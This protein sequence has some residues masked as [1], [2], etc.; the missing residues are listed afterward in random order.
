L[1]TPGSSFCLPA[2]IC[3]S[4]IKPTMF[5]L[6][7]A[8]CLAYVGAWCDNSVQGASGRQHGS[9]QQRTRPSAAR[10]GVFTC[11]PRQ[12]LCMLK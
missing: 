10:P 1:V 12:S 6:P 7:P 4:I 2:L 8:T 9:W 3:D 11:E 5:L